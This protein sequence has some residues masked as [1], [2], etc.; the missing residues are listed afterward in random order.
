MFY[1]RV[2]KLSQG[3]NDEGY[4]EGVLHGREPEGVESSLR[5]EACS[6]SPLKSA[7]L[8]LVQKFSASS[9]RCQTRC[10]IS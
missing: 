2:S 5:L 8:A 4:E 6:R 3:S 1:D 7:S 10:E 9:S